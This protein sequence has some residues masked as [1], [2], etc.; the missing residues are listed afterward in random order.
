MRSL[1][2]N[3]PPPL[4]TFVP[5]QQ[6]Y[7]RLATNFPQEWLTLQNNAMQ[8][9]CSIVYPIAAMLTQLGYQPT[10]D[11]DVNCRTLSQALQTYYRHRHRP[12]SKRRRSGS[13]EQDD[14]HG[15][16]PSSGLQFSSTMGDM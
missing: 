9:Q 13:F 5:V 6:C 8:C 3:V 7:H 4:P 1:P 10:N 16:R 12:S 11:P 2:Y 14:R 15:H